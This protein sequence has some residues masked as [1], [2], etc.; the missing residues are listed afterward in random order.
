MN[1]ASPM[2]ALSATEI[3]AMEWLQ[4][5]EGALVSRIPDK[6]ETDELG[7]KVPGR[8]IFRRLEKLGLCYESEEDPMFEDEPDGPTWTPGLYLTEEGRAWKAP[9]PVPPAPA[10]HRGRRQP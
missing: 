9:P 4:R 10:A 6:T 5:N 1:A 3:D 8:T 2:R 7:F